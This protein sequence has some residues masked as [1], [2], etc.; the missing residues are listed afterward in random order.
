MKKEW[1]KIDN[2]I[3][4]IDIDNVIENKLYALIEEQKDDIDEYNIMRILITDIT[5]I[6]YLYFY[7]KTSS[8]ITLFDK[9][10]FIVKLEISNTGEH[11]VYLQDWTNLKKKVNITG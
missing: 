7:L 3:L 10:Y 1:P 11:F 4:D 5:I 2:S 9:K 8:I 6:E